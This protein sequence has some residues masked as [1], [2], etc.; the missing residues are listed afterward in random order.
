MEAKDIKIPIFEN[1]ALTSVIAPYYEATHKSFLLLS[2]LWTGSRNK[3]EEYFTEF[4][5]VMSIYSLNLSIKKKRDVSKLQLPSELFTFDIDLTDESIIDQFVL[6]IQNI[7]NKKGYYFKTHFLHERVS[8][9]SNMIKL[10]SCN[11]EAL[12]PY[13][14]DMRSIKI[15]SQKSNG[16]SDFDFL[17]KT[18]LDTELNL[19]LCIKSIFN[20]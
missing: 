12:Y 17:V 8:I 16:S 20:I 13:V 7:V 19:C 5:N 4:V 6:F 11:I 14:K 3:L 1:F 10:K 15:I 18:L 9:S 2:T